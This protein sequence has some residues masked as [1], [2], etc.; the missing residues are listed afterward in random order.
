LPLPTF[1]TT[2]QGWLTVNFSIQVAFIAY[3]VLFTASK[4]SAIKDPDSA[5]PEEE[6]IWQ[7]L[8]L[9]DSESHHRGH[10]DQYEQESKQAWIQFKRGANKVV[11]QFA[12]FWFFAWLTWL[13]HYLYLLTS[14]LG[15][16]PESEA[17]RNFVNNLNSLMFI[18]LFMTLTVST[19]TYGPL[20]WARLVSSALGVYAIE[21]LL[22]KVSHGNPVVALT[23]TA[24]S[25]LFASVAL[26]AFV[27]SMNSKFINIPIW[28]VPT[29][30]LY[31]AIQSFYVF[32]EFTSAM[33]NVSAFVE[34]TRITIT[35]FAFI[36]KTILF[37]TVT[38]VLRTGRL[39][40][41][42]IQEGSV[43]FGR[44]KNFAK[45]LKAVKVVEMKI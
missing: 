39:I 9:R 32:F 3:V 23:F 31:A 19:R 1:P 45:F 12:Y 43:H 40:Y 30:Y 37:I 5:K 27:G 11:K 41:F 33:S 24:F 8:E 26:A 13:A 28:L 14:T 35:I 15:W 10:A 21:W 36:L 7:N 44:D 6:E 16:V 38:W 42:M 18:F 4:F 17:T 29:L 22:F 25:G 20:F 2:N 34:K